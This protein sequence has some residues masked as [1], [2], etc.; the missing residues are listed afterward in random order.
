MCTS[1]GWTMKKRFIRAGQFTLNIE[2]IAFIEH[3]EG[4]RIELVFTALSGGQRR[5]AVGLKG[6]ATSAECRVSLFW[7][8]QPRFTPTHRVWGAVIFD[9]D[10]KSTRLNSSHL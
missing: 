3:Y 4:D 2:Q 7:G 1:N 9:Q 8:E 10:R 6:Q 5:S